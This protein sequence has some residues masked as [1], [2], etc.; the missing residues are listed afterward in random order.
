[1]TS[2]RKI[3]VEMLRELMN[4]PH[5]IRNMSV[6]AHVDH[7][8]STL[9]D[10]LLAANELI[11]QADVG[12]KRG[13]DIGKVEQEKG[14]TIKS[15][16]VSLLYDTSETFFKHPSGIEQ[17]LVNLIDSPG[18]VDFSSEVTAALRL[19]DGAL[20][21]VDCVEGACVQTETVLRQALAERIKP[22]LA[23]NK[24]DRAFLELQLS[25]EEIY[26]NFCQ[27]ISDV[28]NVIQTY[29]DEAMGDLLV[30]P[31]KGTVAFSAGRQGWAFT[32]RDF[33]RM[34][35]K[36][37]SIS[38][39]KLMEKLWG[40]NYYDPEAKRWTS[41]S[42]SA[43]G[44]RLTR[45]FCQFILDPIAKIFK[46][47]MDN[48]IEEL[49][50]LITK[51][52]NIR[53]SADEKEKLQGKDLLKVVMQRWLPASRSLLE[54]IA[55]HLPSPVQAQKYRVELL[56]R[57]PMDDETA[58]AIRNCDPNGPFVMY[59]SKLIPTKD[60][61]RF[62][63]FGRVFSGTASAQKVTI[64]GNN[65][66]PGSKTDLYVDKSIQR[67]VLMMCGKAEAIDSVPCGNTCGLVG[68]DTFLTKSG[69]VASSKESFPII[70]MK[71]SV[72]PVVRVAVAPKNPADIARL[73]EALKKL[74]KTDSLVQCT[75]E[76]TGEHI[77]ACAGELHM[78]ICLGE[79][80]DIMGQSPIVVSDPVVSL[81]ET[82]I[83]TSSQVCLSKSPNNHNRLYAI[84]EP[85]GEQLVLALESKSLDVHGDAKEVARKLVSEHGW[86]PD[87]SKKIW[88]F[89]PET[90]DTNAIVDGTRGVQYMNEIRD[91]V[92]GGFQEACRRGVL[93]DEELRGVRF[94][95]MDATLHGDTI[96]RGGGQIIPATRRVFNASLL[97]ASPRLM[98]PIYTVDVQCPQSAVHT[99]YEVLNMRRGSV[100]EEMSRPG[101]TQFNL[102]GYL[103]VLE[104]FGFTEAL[105]AATSGSAFPQLVFDH[106]SVL[107]SDPMEEG[108]A[109]E[110]IRASR[111]R[112]G[113]DADIPP[114]D[115]FLDKL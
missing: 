111:R 73:V 69:T 2:K 110:L 74:S 113:L 98:E 105:R 27:W 89:G 70:N 66:D 92:V 7:G 14:I 81:R 37:F 44:K 49:D 12:N 22:V 8:K 86:N 114:L 79:L 64:M 104:S 35:A 9:T 108:R 41:N 77:V 57:G 61:S 34:Y 18:H 90:R 96:H 13:T 29:E 76:P 68:V 43:S 6:I 109:R 11:A 84:A 99:V 103:P 50:Q 16:G 26:N 1:M 101:T 93:A 28:N 47:C 75:V 95:L 48:N 19:T 102:K 20:V 52:L 32:L 36:K 42:T 55:T 21:L 106:W 45:G 25:S 85:L 54:M 33:A 87:F 107:D 17:F 30:A 115:R 58:N 46:T 5:C 39:D 4:N 65:Y 59:I 91:N 78:E 3:N 10:S 80:R 38:E 94:T 67:V 83:E 15:T 63:A 62:Y 31:E 72:S 40:E 56:Y 51:G 112:K 97:T 60:N 24:L 100:V 88:A 53:V 82:V 23:I 71:Y